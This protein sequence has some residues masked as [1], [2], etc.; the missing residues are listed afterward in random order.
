MYSRVKSTRHL[1]AIGSILPSFKDAT[2]WGSGFAKDYSSIRYFKLFSFYYKNFYKTDIRAVRGP[3]TKYVF[4][5][6]GI[7]CPSV[8]GDPAIL[9][10]II[11]SPKISDIKDY[12]IVPHYTE[13]E[14]YKDNAN[15]IST[16]TK[17]YKDFIDKICSSKLVISS[18]LH[19]IIIAEAYGVP[20][21]MLSNNS[22]SNIFK[23]QD[24]Y[25]STGREHFPIAKTIDEALNTQYIPL[26]KDVL[27][28]M[29]RKLI[30]S[31]PIDLWE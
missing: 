26:N 29:Q 10:P 23:Y 19:G 1:Y 5:K 6:I 12:T 24:Y 16:F 11:Y 18:S 20:A 30:E 7:P 13:W 25:F 2:I 14:K 31:F 9:L 21:I 22:N 3:L 28:K 8:Y 15:Y 17:D 4:D 27:S